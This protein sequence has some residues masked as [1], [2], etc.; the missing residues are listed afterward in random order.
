[1]T[2]YD[3]DNPNQQMIHNCMQ[4]RRRHLNPI[5]DWTTDE[6][7][8][9]IHEYN[10][11][12]CKL[13][14][15]GFKRLGCIGCPMGSVEH[16]LKEFEKYPKYKQAYIRAFDKMIEVRNGG[17]TTTQLIQER[18]SSK[19]TQETDSKCKAQRMTYWNCG[20]TAYEVMKWWIK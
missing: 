19:N 12:Y 18:R 6:V 16:R 2:N 8:E 4:H 11:P 10:I 20:S 3:P 17:G 15:E 13:Y 7:W 14:D 1:M 5:I 9:F